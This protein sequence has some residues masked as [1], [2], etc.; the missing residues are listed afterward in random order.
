MLLA[1]PGLRHGAVVC[2]CSQ[3]CIEGGGV[4]GRQA[5]GVCA[6]RQGGRWWCGSGSEAMLHGD[7][8][9]YKMR[10]LLA[11]CEGSLPPPAPCLAQPPGCPNIIVISRE[12]QAEKCQVRFCH[13]PS[14]SSTSPP[15]ESQG[16]KAKEGGEPDSV[17]KG[18]V[19]ECSKG[20]ACSVQW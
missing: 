5:G 18:K 8:T 17:Y 16:Q 7:E 12:W 10:Q 14:S 9:R 15:S 20:K 4:V 6:R 1:V 3:K 2:M 13:F 19:H 11:A